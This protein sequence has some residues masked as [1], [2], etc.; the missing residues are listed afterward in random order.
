MIDYNKVAKGEGRQYLRL[1]VCEGYFS[2]F[3]DNLSNPPFIKT[4]GTRE[5]LLTP[6]MRQEIM[7]ILNKTPQF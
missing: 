2:P 7:A 6:E 4:A 1:E 5:F 3:H